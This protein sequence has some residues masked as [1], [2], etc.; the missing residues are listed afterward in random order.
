MTEKN[1]AS[2]EEILKLLKNS[3]YG[4]YT[5]NKYENPFEK[6]HQNAL[7]CSDRDK[8]PPEIKR[9]RKEILEKLEQM[10]D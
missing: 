7:N 4:Y 1:Y 5:D 8:I 6:L 10:E 2:K 3:N 9:K